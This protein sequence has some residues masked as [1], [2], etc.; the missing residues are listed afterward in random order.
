M[1]K[2]KL[3]IAAL[4][5]SLF[6]TQANAQDSTHYDLGRIQ[7]KKD[8][9]Q[10]VTVKGED[11]EKMPFTNLAE[12]INVWFYGSYSNSSTLV[13]VIDGNLVNDVNAYSI[14]DIDEV[15][16]IQNA[17]THIAGISQQ[18][19]QMVLIKTKR[20]KVKGSGVTAVAQADISKLY[21]NNIRSYTATPEQVF[22]YQTGLKTS[23]TLYQQYYVSAY[24]NTG[25]ILLLI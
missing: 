18:Q 1:I 21:T 15:T 8:F 24:Q 23:T 11:L 4:A 2:P 10:S 17:V 3:L 9:T 5:I 12:A 16:L 7:L 6:F 14:Y 20:S 19:Q 13:Y 25:N 22:D